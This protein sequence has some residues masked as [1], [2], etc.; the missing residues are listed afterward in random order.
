[1]YNKANQEANTEVQAGG[2]IKER[3][4]SRFE[5]AREAVGPHW[6]KALAEA[7]A[8]FNTKAGYDT[9]MAVSGAASSPR[10][11][12]VDRIERVTLALEKLAG[13]ENGPVV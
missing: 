12:N 7:D 4:L 5:R 3:L 13:I 8:Y 11:A 10:Q 6:R 2:S 9:M 1:M